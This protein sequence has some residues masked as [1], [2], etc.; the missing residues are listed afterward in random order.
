MTEVTTSSP[1]RGMPLHTKILL[2]LVVG[3][4]LGVAAN[5]WD[6]QSAAATD[7]PTRLE[8]FAANVAEPL[9][10]VFLR[11]VLSVVVPLV[12]SALVLG[13]LGLGDVRRLGRVGIR[14]LLFTLLLSGLSVV[15]GLTAVNLIRPGDRLAPERRE[16]LQTLYSASATGAVESAKKAKPLSQILLDLIPENPLQEMVGALD[17]SSKGN[18]MLAVMCFALLCGVA[19]STLSDERR[20]PLVAVLE[21]IF[22]V[23]MTIIG[24]AMWLAPY[25]VACLMFA[26]V[27]RI[28][29][30]VLVTL[31]WFVATVLI[32]LSIQLFVVYSLTLWIFA[33][34]SPRQFFREASDAML[35]A[36]ATSSS[37]ATL[38]TALRVA[39]ENLRIPP[40]IARFVLTVGSTANQNGTA[41][42]EGVVVLFL[43]QVFGVELTLPQQLTVVLMS[44]LAG[45]GTAGVPGGSLPL[46]V[47]VLRSI[48]VPGEGIAIILGVDRV[49]DMCRTVLN[50]TGDL[51]LAACVAA[52]EPEPEPA[53]AA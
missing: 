52:E 15:I 41:L 6:A 49:L 33:R 39:Q 26:L 27:L 38:P 20:M 47:V 21:G 51:T 2:G 12:F 25:G 11:L 53:P 17:G 29:G 36:F 16:Q 43:A 8:W 18:G 37:N 9:G 34:R 40:E 31:I 5:A 32:G 50:V 24:W 42:Y 45:V 10:K 46:I 28:G 19:L 7:E 44:V 13:V 23:T 4:L 22:D 14:S 3:A 48:G 1:R 35:T 30:E